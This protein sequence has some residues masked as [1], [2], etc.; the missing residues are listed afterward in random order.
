MERIV[1]LATTT[2][3]IFLELRPQL[4]GIGIFL[5]DIFDTKIRLILENL[6]F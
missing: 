5:E 1:A 4:N 3:R 2:I 6:K